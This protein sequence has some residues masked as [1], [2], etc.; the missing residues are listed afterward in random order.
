L[1]AG[2]G[3]RHA[4]EGVH[5][6]GSRAVSTCHDSFIPMYRKTPRRLRRAASS[7]DIVRKFLDSLSQFF[8][9]L[10]QFLRGLA[11]FLAARRE[12]LATLAQP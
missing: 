6:V 5:G 2:V 10:A 7:V 11:Q 8:V 3:V 4:G 12:P 9:C 1:V